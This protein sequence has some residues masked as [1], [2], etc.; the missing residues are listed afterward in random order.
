MRIITAL[1]F[2]LLNTNIAVFINRFHFNKCSQSIYMIKMKF[3]VADKVYL[4]LFIHHHFYTMCFNENFF[5]CFIRAV[6][7]QNNIRLFGAGCASFIPDKY[8]LYCPHAV[9]ACRFPR[10]N[11][12]RTVD[13]VPINNGSR[14]KFFGFLFFQ[15]VCPC[16]E[17][18]VYCCHWS[19]CYNCRDF[20]F[21]Q[22]VIINQPVYLHHGGHRFDIFKEG[23]VCPAHQFPLRYVCYKH[24]DLRTTCCIEAPACCNALFN[25]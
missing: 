15:H 25:F 20:N 13:R 18:D 6:V 12:C 10:W 11:K 1:F 23:S 16:L 4:P 17:F 14:W 24:P 9:L 3:Y 22:Q 21:H 8:S 7:I 19:V 2:Q 5:Q